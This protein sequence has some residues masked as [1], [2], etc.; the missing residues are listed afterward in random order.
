MHLH[1]R[2]L[3]SAQSENA[4]IASEAR[5]Y[6]KQQSLQLIRASLVARE[7]QDS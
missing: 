4:G 5:L 1:W 6:T 3:V 2:S 7:L